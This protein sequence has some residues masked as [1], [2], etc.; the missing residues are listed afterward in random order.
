MTNLSPRRLVY[1]AVSAL[2]AAIVMTALVLVDAPIRASTV[3]LLLA[4]VVI[5][6]SLALSAYYLVAIRRTARA[7]NNPPQ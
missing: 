7:N 2:A 1:N 6:I 4:V 5:I 3:A